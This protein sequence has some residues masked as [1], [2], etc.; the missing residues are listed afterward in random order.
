[1]NIK[2]V[3][4]VVGTGSIWLFA[5]VLLTAG[6]MDANSR[7]ID[8][9]V[10]S[11][12]HQ[13]TVPS[14]QITSTLTSP[15][16]KIVNSIIGNESPTA[17]PNADPRTPPQVV[18]QRAGPQQH[19]AYFTQ[20][21]I[22]V[23]HYNVKDLDTSGA[24][25]KLSAINYAFAGISPDSKCM[26]FDAWADYQK[27]FS[28]D[29]VSGQ[30]DSWNDANG[31]AGNFNQLKQLKAKHPKLKILISVGGWTLSGQFSTAVQPANL[32]SFV[33]SCVDMFIKGNISGLAPG[34]AAGIFDGIDIDWEYPAFQRTD[35]DSKGGYKFSP[36]DTQNYTA[37]LAEFRKQL[38]SNHLLTVAAPAGQDKY[39][40]I[41][42]NKI[43]KYLDWINLMTFDYHGG[44]DKFTDIQAPLFCHPKDPSTSVQETY[45]IDNTIKAYLQKGVPASKILL[46]LPFYGH[47]WTNV[48][49]KNNGLFQ[50]TSQPAPGLYPDAP[51][52][53]DSKVLKKLTGQ[54]YTAHRDQVTK[55]FWIFNGSTL[56][57]YDDSQEITTKMNYA[58]SQK[59]GGAFCWSIDGDD[60]S[61]LHAMT[62]S[63]QGEPNQGVA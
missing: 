27:H 24:A 1:M 3:S 4:K 53:N 40:K 5:I 52:V 35:S 34:A 21:G 44:W 7:S 20:W 26:S 31:L 41:Q 30:A 46:G 50:S 17:I 22:Y 10:S 32:K 2:R 61:L 29:S 33:R 63:N 6:S 36:D 45:C 47:G 28:T 54:G 55:G 18:E 57:S 42:L 16:S 49:N 12:N 23:R 11:T 59:L 25:S 58:R 14:N 9:R 15:N 56:W 38:G 8:S 43:G 19:V 48:A 37:M 51:G 62:G 39:S 13:S 60:G